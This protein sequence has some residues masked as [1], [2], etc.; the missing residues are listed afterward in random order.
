MGLMNTLTIG[1]QTG[2]ISLPYATCSTAAATAAKTCS[3][4]N[5]SLTSGAHITVKFTYNNTASSPTLNVNSTGAKTIR[6][7]GATLSS[8]QYWAAG[9]VVDFVYDGTYWNAIGA[10]KDNNTTYS[11]ASSSTLGLIKIGY[12]ENGNNYPVELD[13]N[14]KAYVNVPW[15]DTSIEAVLDDDGVLIFSSTNITDGDGVEY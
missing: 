8:T 3:F 1:N 6:Y 13:A 4:T 7:A 10:N 5:F 15:I 2:V 12:T 14:S 11:Q 9:Q